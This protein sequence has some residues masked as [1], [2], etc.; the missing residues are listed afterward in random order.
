MQDIGRRQLRISYGF[1]TTEQIRRAVHL[2]REAVEY[3]LSL[4]GTDAQVV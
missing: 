1:E 4:T 2:I 3:S